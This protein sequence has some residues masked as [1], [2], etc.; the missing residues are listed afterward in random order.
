MHLNLDSNAPPS[1]GSIELNGTPKMPT[2]VSKN[3]ALDED[4]PLSYDSTDENNGNDEVDRALD[5]AAESR[6]VCSSR[7]APQIPCWRCYIRA[8]EQ[9]AYV[10]SIVH[11]FVTQHPCPFT[12]K[13][14]RS[15]TVSCHSSA[16][17]TWKNMPRLRTC[18]RT[19]ILGLRY[20]RI[21]V[22]AIPQVHVHAS[23]VSRRTLEP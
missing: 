15:T 5:R 6:T 13:K 11:S 23:Q 1:Y 12:S 4:D 8:T 9:K 17:E 7:D 18:L 22:S 19:C 3:L 21:H 14:H 10:D 20:C 2:P 16:A